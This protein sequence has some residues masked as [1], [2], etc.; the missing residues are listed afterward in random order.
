MLASAI[1]RALWQYAMASA[2]CARFF[3]HTSA[4]Y[5]FEGFEVGWRL[6]DVLMVNH[7]VGRLLGWRSRCCL[8]DPP[9]AMALVLE[10]WLVPLEWPFVGESAGWVWR[11]GSLCSDGRVGGCLRGP[12]ATRCFVIAAHNLLTLLV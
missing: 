9:A 11:D 12:K 7:D 10:K 8:R 5:R 2:M 1:A 4:G 6:L 3:V